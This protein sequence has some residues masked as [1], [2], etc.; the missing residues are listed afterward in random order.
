MRYLGYIT[1]VFTCLLFSLVACQ[2][3]SDPPPKTD[4]RLTNHYC[5][6]PA[7]VN[8]NWGFPGV[9][10]STICYYPANVYKGTYLFKDSIF[11]SNN[12]FTYAYNN[13]DSF[14]YIYPLSKTKIGVLG[15]CANGDTLKFTVDRSLRA[16]LD[17]SAL[18]A[19]Q[20]FC[21][22][23]DTVT[24]TITLDITDSTNKTFLVD[25]TVASDTGINF[26][27]GSAKKQ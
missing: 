16:V 15:F 4:P 24:G 23:T 9:P 12:I 8:Y 6:D 19:G 10:D 25:L 22:L 5:N 3:W 2:K 1:I 21:S 11:L 20:P 27:R 26:H 14:L 7:A 17:S 18:G 13:A